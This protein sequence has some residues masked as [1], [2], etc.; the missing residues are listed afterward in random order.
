[1]SAAE[2]TSFVKRQIEIH[3]SLLAGDFGNGDNVKIIRGLACDVSIDKVGLPS[4][5]TAKVKIYGML[6]EDMGKFSTLSFGNPLLMRRN[7]ISI[8]AGDEKSGLHLAYKGNVT[9]AYADFTGAPDVAFVLEAMTGFFASTTPAGPASFQGSAGVGQ[10]IGGLA[11][12]MGMS[13]QDRGVT[14]QLN[15]PVLNGSPMEKAQAA[16]NAAKCDMIVDDDQVIIA[17]K[18]VPRT[19][20]GQEVLFSAATGMKGYPSFS[21]T[22][23]TVTGLY[24][25]EVRQGGLI[26]IESVVPRA[27]GSWRVMEIHHKLTAYKPGGGDWFTTVGA[28]PLWKVLTA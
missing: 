27:S 3:L 7:S 14:T 16:A 11:K 5:N 17:P 18:G 6:L 20:A 19:P 2:N 9:S 1:M 28:V 10:I 21:S 22:G 25:P 26:S 23:V 24:R 4:K 8:Y 12:D 13:F 15:S